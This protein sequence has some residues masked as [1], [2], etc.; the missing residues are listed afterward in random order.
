MGCRGDVVAEATVLVIQGVDQGLRFRIGERP[1]TIG[2][3]ARNQIRI[4]DTEVSRKHAIVQPSD[5]G[6]ELIDADS[7]NGTFVNA[8]PVH[9]HRLSS[10]DQI[11][12]GRSVLL[13]SDTSVDDESRLIAQNVAVVNLSDQAD[14]SA[15]IDQIG[16]ISG[17][18]LL[19]HVEASS[20]ADRQ[21]TLANLQ[22]LYRISEDALSPSISLEQA[23]HR[24]LSLTIEVLGADH[25]CF[26]IT[27]P[28][29]G[30]I[31]PQVFA[32]REGIQATETM[33]VSRSIVEF[34]QQE[35]QGVRTSDAQAD[36]RFG[37]GQ[38]ILQAG[39]R[40]AM[41]VPMQG[42][43]ELLGVVYVDITTHP[44]QVILDDGNVNKFTEE[45]LRLLVAIGRQAAL[46]IENHRY[47]QAYVKAERLAAMGQ[48]IATLSHHIKNILQGIRGGSYLIDMGLN[49]HSEEV[50]GKGWKIVEK[51]QTKIYR[52][53]MDMLTFSKERQPEIQSGRVLGVV[54]DVCELMQSRAA[55][56]HVQFQLQPSEEVPEAQFDPEAIH[57]AVLNVA[58]NAIDAVEGTE[59]GAVTLSIG[60]DEQLDQVFVDVADNGPGIPPDQLEVIF[61]LFE[62]TKGTRGTGL[63]LAVS[64]KILREHGGE[65][66]VKSTPEAGSRFRLA[67]PR[68]EEEHRQ[69]EGQTH[70]V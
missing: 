14:H 2:R 7:S 69:I 23:L 58:T 38:S 55:E 28:S 61:N 20:S 24:I 10:G 48:T 32:T 57:Q 65:I 70:S 1:V 9:R 6:F 3:G 42:H 16:H 5:G 63:G 13:F 27:D 31:V 62:S 29:S 39:I 45:K 49:D 51:N 44:D 41:C 21:Q 54:K 12:V 30:E 4:V 36:E 50:I 52:L 25:G 22:A 47:Q 46:A 67:W 43:Y 53:V 35:H 33:T 40:E 11:Q 19:R 8:N 60:Y 59:D 37:G 66:T 56:C 17:T 68:A 18:D 26:L 15:I 34:V 64:Q